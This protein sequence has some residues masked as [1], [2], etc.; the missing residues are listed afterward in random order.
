MNKTAK[1]KCST[2]KRE[3][4]LASGFVGL[5]MN[6]HPERKFKV[7]IEAGWKVA[8][9]AKCPDCHKQDRFVLWYHPESDCIF[10]ADNNGRCQGDTCEELGKAMFKTYWSAKQ[11]CALAFG[12]K[13]SCEYFESAYKP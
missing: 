3:L 7:A 11:I 2:C 4:I 1:I 10:W 12:D 9:L 8:P 5:G 6:L 13:F